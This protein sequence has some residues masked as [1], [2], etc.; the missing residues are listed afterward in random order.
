MQALSFMYHIYYVFPPCNDLGGRCSYTPFHT[1]GN[2]SEK[3]DLSSWE[4]L[5][6]GYQHR[7]QSLGQLLKLQSRQTLNGGGH[8]PLSLLLPLPLFLSF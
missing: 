5:V 8:Q 4:M 1:S 3:N 6:V 7:F 2:R